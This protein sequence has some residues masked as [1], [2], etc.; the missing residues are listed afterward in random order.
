MIESRGLATSVVG[1]VRSHLVSTGNP[2]SLWV[3]FPLGRPFGEP[4]DAAFQR[5]VLLDALRLLER[6]DGPVIIEDF[7][8]DA[9]SM[10]TG[11][12]WQAAIQLAGVARPA[13]RDVA[14]WRN[15]LAAELAHVLPHWRAVVE[16]TGRTMVGNSRL[17][18]EHWPAF[19]SRFLDG[20]LPESPVAG[21]SPA[22][23]ARFIADDVKA[24]YMEAAHAGTSNPSIDQINEWFWETALAADLLRA[25]RAAALDS[26]H[27]GFSTACSRFVVPGPYIERRR[28]A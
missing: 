8:D 16:R 20:S 24:L 27:K 9:P 26:P 23:M 28:A 7:P 1:L 21:L 5:R 14:G 19:V 18:P 3:P 13:A 6:P 10:H 12:G 15:A 22:L 25:L 11:S 17:A 2:R 4:G